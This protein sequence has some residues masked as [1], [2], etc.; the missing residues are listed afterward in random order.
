[1]RRWDATTGQAIGDPLTGHTDWVR[2]VAVADVDGRPVI[3]TGGDD[4][5]V[6]RWD[7]TTGQAI[8]DPLTGHTDWVLA[9]AVADVDGRPVIVTGGSDGTVRRWDATTGQ[10]IGDPLTGHTDWVLAVAVA[11]VDGRPVIV[12]GGDD[13]TVRRWDATTGQAIGDPLTGHTDWVRAV[14]VADVDGRPVIVT[15]GDD[16]TV[17]RWDATTGQA[18]GD[19]L[20]GHTDWVRAV[21]VADVDG[22]PVIVTGGSDGTVRRW[23]ATTGQAIGDPLTGHTGWVRAV[24]VADVDGRPVIVT[25]GSDGTVRRWDATTGQAIGDPL[26]GHTDWVRAVAVADVDGRPVIVT[27]GSDGTVRRWDATTGQAIGDPLTGHTDWVRAVAVAD[28]DGRPVIV[29]GGDDGTVRRWDATTGQAIGDP[30]TGHTDWVRAVAVADVD[31]R[32]VIVTGGGYGT[33]RR[34]DA[35]TGQAIGDPL[36]GH[37]GWVR[38]VAVAD[39]DGRPVI[40]T[41][42]DDGTVRVW[43]A[44]TGGTIAAVPA[45]SRAVTSLAPGG[46]GSSNLLASGSADGSVVVWHLEVLATANPV[47]LEDVFTGENTGAVDR[48]LRGGLAAHLAQRLRQLT[49]NERSPSPAAGDLTGSG[50]VH[51]DG[52]WGAGK[53]TLIERLLDD[54]ART[55]GHPIVVRYDAWRQAAIA[56]EWWSVA[57][58]VRRAVHR[59]RVVPVRVLM[60][61]AEVSRRLGRSTSTWVALLVVAAAAVFGRWLVDEPAGIGGQLEAVLTLVT[62]ISGLLALVFVLSRGLFWT[63]PVLGRLHLRT[64]D[65]P[66]GEIS[67]I[68]GQLRRWSPREHVPQRFIDWLFVLWVALTA[69]MALAWRPITARWSGLGEDQRTLAVQAAGACAALVCAW[70]LARRRG[71]LISLASWVPGAWQALRPGRQGRGSTPRP[72]ASLGSRAV[73]GLNRVRWSPRSVAET[74]IRQLSRALPAAA[75]VALVAA[76]AWL[77]GPVWALAPPLWEAHLDPTT[78]TWVSRSAAGVIIYFTLSVLLTRLPRRMVLLIIDDLDR[79][80]ADRVVRLLETVHTVLRERSAPR[81]WRR[82]RRPAPLGVI[83]LASGRWVRDAFSTHY[84]TFDRKATEET[85]HDLGADFLQKVFDHSVLVPTLSPEQTEGLIHAVSRSR[86]HAPPPTERRQPRHLGLTPPIRSAEPDAPARGP[87][88][89]PAGNGSADGRDKAPGV[90]AATPSSDTLDG[91]RIAPDGAAAAQPVTA[92]S[93]Y[94]PAGADDPDA[95]A[96]DR[97]SSAMTSSIPQVRDQP[98]PGP[99]TTSTWGTSARTPSGTTPDATAQ[100]ARDDLGVNAELLVTHL[101]TDY[102]EILPGNPRLII[103]VASA[104][105]ML[106]AVAR[107]LNLETDAEPANEILVRASVIWVRFP[108]LVDELLDTDRPPVT[109]PTDPDCPPRWRRR[110]VQQVLRMRS[111]QRLH[112]EDLALYYGRFFE[113]AVPAP[114][115]E[116]TEPLR[117]VLLDPGPVESTNH[118]GRHGAEQ[119]TP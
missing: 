78:Q 46:S 77:L 73:A 17:R 67:G 3:V 41:G 57:S 99:P 12:T 119:G 8:G 84:A 40:V 56:P 24:A 103:R 108:V 53:T 35:T 64:D 91:T 59:S 71:A 22:R 18:I 43:D 65:N 62:T 31:G 69:T 70:L 11:D 111:G 42:G 107:S 72:R 51:V 37:T 113:P 93:P 114:P 87:S 48:L 66:L 1:M 97:A 36:T 100:S 74:L 89:N 27:G 76:A 118:A 20:T 7:A 14:A 28:V 45:S 9:V 29:T 63:A 90:N 101:L 4:G 15:G 98:M 80:D 19:P 96:D 5:T 32:P 6:R 60:T 102:A 94:A 82:W 104:W 10:A 81:F 38:A 83:V 39:V 79:C 92:R 33:V 47:G 95:D 61:C 86:F 13:G 23:D 34:W 115:T 117:V 112:P 54:H 16:G 26:T 30:L 88:K 55:M 49:S 105:A 58:E 106:R 116:R 109:D 25:G 85:V 75:A 50:I 21:A 2:A 68:V 52:R 44:S 110:D